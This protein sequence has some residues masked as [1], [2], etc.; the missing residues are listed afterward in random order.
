MKAMTKAEIRDLVLTRGTLGPVRNED[1]YRYQFQGLPSRRTQLPL[2]RYGLGSKRVLEA[3]CAYGGNL[4]FW[5][6]GSL[7][8]DIGEEQTK[9]AQALGLN[10]ISGDIESSDDMA[11]IPDSYFDAIWCS[12][13]LEHLAAPHTALT[14]LR[15]KLREDGLLFLLVPIIPKSNLLERLWKVYLRGYNTFA[16]SEHLYA[17]TRQ[18]I[19]YVVGQAG[20]EVIESNIFFPALG[21]FN[22]LVNT[23]IGDSWRQITVVAK[24]TAAPF[25][26][27]RKEAPALKSHHTSGQ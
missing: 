16:A 5:G 8:I 27:F 6:E 23:L 3:G 10:V 2:K 12:H 11:K 17:F 1:I 14:T 25:E 9:F 18:S 13:V 15:S 26:A 21:R 24:R 19:T 7:G 22:N 4:L 20:Y